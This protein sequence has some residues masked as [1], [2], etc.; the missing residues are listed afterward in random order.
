MGNDE[1]IEC[2]TTIRGT[3][4][5]TT[6]STDIQSAKMQGKCKWAHITKPNTKFEPV[7]SIDIVLENEELISRLKEKGLNVK[8]DR[9]GDFILQIKKKCKNR[10]GD[11]LSPPIVLH[12]GEAFDGLVGNG[13]TVTVYFGVKPW[14]MAG[15][16]GVSC[17][18]NKVEVNELVEYKPKGKVDLDFTTETFSDDLPF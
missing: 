10:N 13:S 17:F 15:R 2:I 12:E 14:A 7:W 8:T 16:K 18:L 3:Y 4:I 9:D 11:D 1:T 5:M 6:K